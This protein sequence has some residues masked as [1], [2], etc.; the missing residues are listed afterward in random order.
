MPWINGCFEARTYARGDGER[1]PVL[2]DG[3]PPPAVTVALPFAT[4]QLVAL[5]A[6]EAVTAVGCVMVTDFIAVQPLAS[7]TV[8]E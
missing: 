8:R 1:K 3:V 7:V 6:I 5:A 4:P 2:R